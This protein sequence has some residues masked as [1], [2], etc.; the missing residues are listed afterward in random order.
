M[1]S[2]QNISYSSVL[3]TQLEMFSKCVQLKKH[4][5]IFKILRVLFS[6]MVLN[7]FFEAGGY[8]FSARSM[9]ILRKT[10]NKS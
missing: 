1:L 8:L 6:K 9:F 3:K 5:N 4:P 7:F 2:M 10:V